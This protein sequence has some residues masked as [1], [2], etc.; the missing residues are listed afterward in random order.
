MSTIIY[1]DPYYN[2]QIPSSKSSFIN[3]ENLVIPIQII[4]TVKDWISWT[5][6]SIKDC[7]QAIHK[8]RRSNN[9]KLYG[10]SIV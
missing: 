7:K 5:V 10:D 8:R 9:E 4:N 3:E 1:I 2:T 6:Q